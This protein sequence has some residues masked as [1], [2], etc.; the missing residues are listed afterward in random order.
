MFSVSKLCVNVRTCNI[1]RNRLLILMSVKRY[2][3]DVWAVSRKRIGTNVSAVDR[4]HRWV[5]NKYF[6]WVLQWKVL[7]T[8]QRER[9]Y[10]MN[11][12][13]CSNEWGRNDRGIVWGG[14]LYSVRPEVIKEGHL[15]R[16][17]AIPCGGGV[18]YLHRNSASRRR[19]RKGKS[20]IWDS[21][22]WS[23]VPRGSDRRMTALARSSS[24]SKRQ[25][26]PLV[27]ES[28]ARQQ[29]R[30]CLTVISIWS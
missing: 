16:S 15:H 29:T 11:T 10:E 9:C 7:N 3:C 14:D 19:R 13:F 6:P 20:Q 27:R 12:Y 18:E 24:S 17:P 5:L 28:A 1:W 25:T 30:N 21:K 22:V 26:R 4:N 23:R 8:W 2:Y